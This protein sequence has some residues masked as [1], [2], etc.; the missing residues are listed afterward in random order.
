MTF[1][2]ENFEKRLINE[3]FKQTLFYSPN[4][5]E[6][7][8]LVE[9]LGEYKV[10][11]LQIP[12]EMYTE[13][14]NYLVRNK[15]HLARIYKDMKIISKKPITYKDRLELLAELAENNYE[16]IEWERISDYLKKDKIYFSREEFNELKALLEEFAK[17]TN[18]KLILKQELNDLSS[19]YDQ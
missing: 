6:L 19:I 2:K 9:N 17:N 3:S 4:Q 8:L 16:K 10:V 1:F 18:T 14:K 7:K 11:W 13:L 5:K 12:P 15:V